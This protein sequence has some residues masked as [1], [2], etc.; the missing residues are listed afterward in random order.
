MFYAGYN[1]FGINFEFES[2]GSWQ[3]YAFF[4]KKERDEWLSEHEYNPDI[5]SNYI[6]CRISYKDMKRILPCKSWQKRYCV[7]LT[8]EMKVT[9]R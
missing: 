1:R 7:H 2:K 3:V 5:S 9:E 6:A 8:H 4:T